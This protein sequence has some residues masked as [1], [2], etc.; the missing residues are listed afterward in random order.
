MFHELIEFEKFIL[1]RRVFK[2]YVNSD[3]A[4]VLTGELP[5]TGSVEEEQRSP[6]NSR[7]VSF[8]SEAQIFSSI[9][10]QKDQITAYTELLMCGKTQVCHTGVQWCATKELTKH[11][12]SST[13][14]VGYHLVVSHTK[15]TLQ[16]YTWLFN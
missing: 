2:V 3:I 10:S 1:T 9:G 6:P 14:V 12:S 13:T 11:C 7:R 8:G 16:Y 4:E 15:L 5:V